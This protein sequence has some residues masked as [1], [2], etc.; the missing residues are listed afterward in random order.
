MGYEIKAINFKSK[1]FNKKLVPDP[2]IHH[3]H[4]FINEVFTFRRLHLLTFRKTIN[5][6]IRRDIR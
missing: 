4:H 6:I 3:S 2:L 5:R 1:I